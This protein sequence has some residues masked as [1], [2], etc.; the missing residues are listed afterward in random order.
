MRQVTIRQ[1]QIFVEA[2]RTL[3][4][5]RVAERLHLTPAAISFQIKQ[6][7]TIS[8]F[9]LF[10]HLGKKAALT[11]PGMALLGYA[12]S[13]LQSLK[14]ADQALRA[15]K[16]LSGGRVTVGL[17]S[18]AKYFVPHLLTRFQTEYPGIVIHLRD[19]NRREIFAALGK[20]D[21]DLA[22]TGRPPDDTGMGLL[23]AAFAEHPSVIIA[24]PTHPLTGYPRL[25]PGVLAGEPFIARE[26]GSGTRQLMDGLFRAASVTPRVTMISSSNETIKQAVMAGMGIALISRHTI[27]L[28][29]HLGLLRT[30]PVDGFPLM[31]SWFV[32]HRRGMPLL[33]IHQRL[34]DFA[35]E[36]GQDIITEM[37]HAHVAVARP[38]ARGMPGALVAKRPPSPA[39][40]RAKIRTK[41][42]IKRRRPD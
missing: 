39:T 4:Y 42:P 26:E 27:G 30:L 10:E 15:L 38:A 14:D 18:T 17:V 20:G 35:L 16:G 36:R 11:E 31:R 28:E 6:L 32:T 21:V 3:S 37:E 22:V 23:A 12:Q 5:A 41:Q 8:G 13:V 40:A 19:G 33:P 29:L 9:A 7:E 1:L 25:P 34:R 24:A 2:A